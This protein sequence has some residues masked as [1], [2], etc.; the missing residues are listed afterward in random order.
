MDQW[1]V[2]RG[3]VTKGP[4]TRAQ[5]AQAA[6]NG[7][8]RMT[9]LLRQ[10][11]EQDSIAAGKVSGLFP[12]TDSAAAG[13]VP[14][15]ESTPKPVH[16]SA[17]APLIA[18]SAM[19]SEA[20]PPA[21]G[22][23]G[24]RW[25]WA[26]AGIVGVGVVGI[27]SFVILGRKSERLNTAEHLVQNDEP[28]SEP[29]IPD[30]KPASEPAKS[31]AK[32]ASK[33]VSPKTKVASK[34]GT[35][36]K[37]KVASKAGARKTK[38]A[39]KGDTTGSEGTLTIA[40]PDIELPPV[41]PVTQP[42]DVPASPA[43]KTG[44]QRRASD[45]R[46]PDPANANEVW[47][48]I[49][50]LSSFNYYGST[51][52]DPLPHEALYLPY[53]SNHLT[54][55]PG[56]YGGLT[57]M[58]T[59]RSSGET[60]NKKRA[61]DL[62]GHYEGIAATPYPYL[63]RAIELSETICRNRLRLGLADE[64]FG[65]T[66]ASSIRVFQQSVFLPSIQYSFLRDA[67]ESRLK[68]S[69]ERENPGYR[70]I[71][72]SAPMSDASRDK[73]GELLKGAGGFMENAKKRSVV[74]GM[75]GYADMAQVDRSA[76]FWQSWLLPLARRCG[77]PAAARPLVN[78]DAVW[79]PTRMQ[80]DYQRLHGYALINVSGQ[81][82]THMV[83]EL[84]S[85]NEWGQK[86]AEYYYFDLLKAGDFMRLVPHLRWERRRLDF[87]N[88]VKLRWSLWADQASEVGREVT[89]TSPK[90]NP[91]AADWRQDYARFDRQGQA[92]GEAM[93]V[94]MQGTIA[95]PSTPERH[96]R[97]LWKAAAPPASYVFR[98]PGKPGRTLILRFLRFDQGQYTFEAEI[99]DP[100]SGKPFDAETPVWTGKFNARPEP[101]ISFGKNIQREI[102]WAFALVRDDQ[103]VIACPAAG[104]PAPRSRPGRSRCLL[105]KDRRPCGGSGTGKNWQTA[106]G[107]GQT[108]AS[109]IRANPTSGFNLRHKRMGAQYVHSLTPHGI[110]ATSQP[111]CPGNLISI[112]YRGA[113][114]N[115][116]AISS[117]E[118]GGADC[119]PAG[120]GW[121]VSRNICSSPAGATEISIRAGRSLSLRNEWSEPTGMLANI[122]A[123]A[124][125]RS[126]S[127]W[128]VISP[129]S[130]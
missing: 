82:L 16:A 88:T 55:T 5:L 63:Q 38:A 61:E 32:P 81:D 91:K 46:A 24:T 11:E 94:M 99:F 7:S 86:G 59:G 84:I 119:A 116:F 47:W 3:Q 40:G 13:A 103:L 19:Q 107:S 65:N 68:Q 21:T 54:A 72:N 22:R 76:Q 104:K 20:S 111:Q 126:S 27:G 71:V 57:N 110:S 23:R 74:S 100:G 29:V 125:M 58:L 123:V 37:A 124:T 12:A 130:T 26:A 78:V 52:S 113:A 97:L 87:A 42:A 115:S 66:A 10:G 18:E 122:P 101:G 60:V 118:G 105:S 43:G 120:S 30:A 112:P 83:V 36:K 15:V 70:V 106:C 50:R 44:R 121:P 80:S 79:G 129:S 67:D 77:G 117:L 28:G 56:A 17:P 73:L 90:P 95:L 33:K 98:L 39:S 35:A 8:L 128:I 108:Q 92:E 102:S 114:S 4:Y 53:R 127:T 34:G 1:Y 85:E 64:Q 51:S 75:L 2:T 49:A 45:A 96:W 48:A 6:S 41:G 109:T 31:K 89:L 25:L 62:L 14:V 69:L 9:D 93:G